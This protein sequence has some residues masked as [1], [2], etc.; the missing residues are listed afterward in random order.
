MTDQ[1]LAQAV[2]DRL[3]LREAEA[4]AAGNRKAM[5]ALRLT[6]IALE[7]VQD[8]LVDDGVI[9]PLS[10]TPKPPRPE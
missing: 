6:H 10:A 3:R 5:K 1:E 4:L 2:A 8:I 7:A 9:A